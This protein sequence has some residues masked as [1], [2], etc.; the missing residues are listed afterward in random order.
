MFRGCVGVAASRDASRYYLAGIPHQTRMTS[1]AT[2]IDHHTG[3]PVLIT[4]LS[5]KSI[6]VDVADIGRGRPLVF[7]HGLVGLNEHWEEVTSRA[8]A[9]ARCVMLQLP[10]LELRG[11]DCSID[12]AS[13]LT[14]SF[15]ERHVREL[16]SE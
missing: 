13:A 7:L 4:G 3:T 5:G 11:D 16:R 9:R 8:T 1:S 6:P 10:L 12:G 14:I 15:L 2:P